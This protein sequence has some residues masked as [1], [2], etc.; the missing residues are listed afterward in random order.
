MPLLLLI[1]LSACALNPPNVPVIMRSGP[2]TG[3]YVKI[4]SGESGEVDD[5]HLLDG[6]TFLDY[7]IEAIYVPIDSYVKIKEFII[8]VCKQYKCTGIGW[9]TSLQN[10][11]Q[12]L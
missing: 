7:S 11:D 2:T 10:I 8:K 3:K 5:N 6:K 1:F 12:N 4:M 9:D